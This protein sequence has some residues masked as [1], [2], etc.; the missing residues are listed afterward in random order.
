MFPAK[1]SAET[2]DATASQVQKNKTTQDPVQRIAPGI[3]SH[4]QRQKRAIQGYGPMSEDMNKN[5]LRAM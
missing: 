1:T 2:L 3:A 5:S 4:S